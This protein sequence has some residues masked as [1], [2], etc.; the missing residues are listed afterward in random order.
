MLQ[1][2]GHI[3]IHACRF[4]K[5]KIKKLVRQHRLEET[6]NIF[7]ILHIRYPNYCKWLRIFACVRRKCLICGDREPYKNSDYHECENENCHLLYCLECW[8]DVGKVCLACTEEDAET[9]SGIDESGV[10]N[11]STGTE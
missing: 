7:T 8:I 4:M 2:V 1:N 9:S 3:F 6:Y 10:E 11:E 5:K